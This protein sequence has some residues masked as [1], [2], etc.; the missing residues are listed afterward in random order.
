[1]KVAILGAGPAGLYA[2]YLLKSRIGAHVEVDI[3]EQNPADATWGFGVVFSAR[4]LEFLNKDDAETHDYIFAH[5]ERWDDMLIKVQDT[6]IKI[7]GVSFSAIGRLELLLLLQE[8]ARSVGIEP[9]FNRVIE[10]VGELQGYDLIVAADGVNS[11]I[12]NTYEKKFGT[13]IEL[14]PNRFIWY[15]TS[16]PFKTLTQTFKSNDEGCFTAHHY[17][18]AK[19]MSTFLIETDEATFERGNFAGMDSPL[20]KR[21]FEE[22]FSSE[23]DG[24]PIVE[25][26]SHWRNFPKMTQETWS[27][28]NMV[29]TGD[30]LHTAHFSIGSGTRLAMEDVIELVSCLSESPNSI[31]EALRLYEERRRPI[32]DTIVTAANTSLD[33]YATFGARMNAAPYDFVYSYIQR[34]GRISLERLRE[35]SPGFMAEYDAFKAQGSSKEAM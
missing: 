2:G 8:R 4:A 32:V 25:N 17:R 34:S 28:E 21:Y 15:G 9:Q 27:H 1:M 11:L 14:H 5:M 6:S 18:Y 24:H 22:L 7:D 30:A 10:S 35:M 20:T 31:S 33:W 3:F 26:N 23:L 12:R 29:L 19:D 13:K 16:K